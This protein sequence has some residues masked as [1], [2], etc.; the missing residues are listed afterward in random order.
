[1]SEQACVSVHVCLEAHLVVNLHDGVAVAHLAAAAHDAPQL[2]RH[3]GITS[4]H[5]VV[6]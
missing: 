3:L 2:L 4:L 5:G 6:V 1:M